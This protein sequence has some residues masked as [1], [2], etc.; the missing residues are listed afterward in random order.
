MSCIL[1]CKDCHIFE[2]L[3]S[4]EKYLEQITRKQKG[5]V[6]LDQPSVSNNGQPL[7]LKAHKYILKETATSRIIQQKLDPNNIW[8]SL[9]ATVGNA[10]LDGLMV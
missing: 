4:S 1:D 8:R 9:M 6:G 5:V 10:G 3:F 7:P 2:A